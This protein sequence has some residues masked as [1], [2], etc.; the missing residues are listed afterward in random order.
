MSRRRSSRCPIC[1]SLTQSPR[2]T[3]CPQHSAEREALRDRSRTVRTS[4]ESRGYDSEHRRIRRQWAPKVAAGQ[5]NCWRCGQPIIPG[6]PWDLGHTDFDRSVY[7][8][9]EHR[10]GNR[11]TAGRKGNLRTC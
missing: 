5:V 11:A 3:Y 1:G 4:P 10:R 9:P 7:R 8:G 6:E 2:H